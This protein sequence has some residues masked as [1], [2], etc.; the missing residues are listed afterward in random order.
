MGPEGNSKMLD[1][2]PVQT[3]EQPLAPTTMA[4][5]RRGVIEAYRSVALLQKRWPGLFGDDARPLASTCVGEIAA[6][7]EWSVPFTK[8]AVVRWKRSVRY[9]QAILK[10][11]ERVNLD[12]SA[13]DEVVDDKARALAQANLDQKHGQ[14]RPQPRPRAP[15]PASQPAPT[16]AEPA[17]PPPPAVIAAVQPEPAPAP[18]PEPAQLSPAE[19]RRAVQ[20]KLMALAKKRIR[21]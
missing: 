15:A 9:C 4:E 17:A 1:A 6:A 10:Y 8:P 18:A 3:E 5:R 11:T 12:G 2:D 16:I 19:T 20:L 7:M 14:S 21:R 13:S